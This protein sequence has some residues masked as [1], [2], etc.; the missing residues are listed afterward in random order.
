MCFALPM[1]MQI[2]DLC[3]W[4]QNRKKSESSIFLLLNTV[5]GKVQHYSGITVTLD[6]CNWE[7]FPRWKDNNFSGQK[8]KTKLCSM[9]FWM[10]ETC[11]EEKNSNSTKKKSL[12]L[13]I[14]KNWSQIWCYQVCKA[15]SQ[16]REVYVSISTFTK[17]ETYC[18]I[19]F[20][21]DRFS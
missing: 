4:T 10:N 8:A 1:D 18:S 17:H 5:I 3:R 21:C 13:K 14:T 12:N 15:P 2:L 16:F 7:V 9:M 11:F 19:K 6:L 20:S